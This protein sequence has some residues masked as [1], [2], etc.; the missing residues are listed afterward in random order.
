MENILKKDIPVALGLI[1]VLVVAVFSIKSFGWR[2]A[3]IGELNKLEHRVAMLE[4]IIILKHELETG[5][6]YQ[7]QKVDADKFAL[8]KSIAHKKIS[9]L[10]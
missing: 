1:L 9:S 4:D 10:L 7:Y 5:V 3:G 2:N 8:K 6:Y